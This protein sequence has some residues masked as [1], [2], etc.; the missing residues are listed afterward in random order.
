MDQ[1]KPVISALVPKALSRQDEAF[2]EAAV[3]PH[4]NIVSAGWSVVQTIPA[5]YELGSHQ[6]TARLHPSVFC[7]LQH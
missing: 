7:W 1:Y 4:K 2:S 5:L 3:A 6:A